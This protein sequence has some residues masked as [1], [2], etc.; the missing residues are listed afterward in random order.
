MIRLNIPDIEGIAEPVEKALHALAALPEVM[1]RN[2]ARE[3]LTVCARLWSAAAGH[4][5]DAANALERKPN[6]HLSKA[7]PRVGKKAAK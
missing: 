7:K 2:E 6:G 5:T 3:H 4:M 1:E